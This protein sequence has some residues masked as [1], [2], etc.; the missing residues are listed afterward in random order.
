MREN[1]VIDIKSFPV[2]E[3]RGCFR[4]QWRVGKVAR[5]HVTCRVPEGAINQFSPSWQLW[6]LRTSLLRVLSAQ[7][8]RKLGLHECPG[9]IYRYRVERSHQNAE[10]DGRTRARAAL[11]LHR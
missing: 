4:R 7:S 9:L 3:D 1:G 10:G 8:N 11:C 2:S 5:S 6:M